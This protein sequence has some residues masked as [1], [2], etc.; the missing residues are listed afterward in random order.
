MSGS[1]ISSLRAYAFRMF[2]TDCAENSSGGISIATPAMR[3]NSSLSVTRSFANALTITDTDCDPNASGS[4][5]AFRQ[6][7]APSTENS[8]SS[9]MP[10]RANPLSVTATAC[11]SIPACLLSVTTEIALFAAASIQMSLPFISATAL[12]ASE[13]SLPCIV[14]IRL[15]TTVLSFLISAACR[16][17]S[18][19]S[20]PRFASRRTRFIAPTASS[21]EMSAE[22][23]RT[24]SNTST[25][26]ARLL[27]ED[28][29]RGIEGAPA[30]LVDHSG[31]SR[32]ATGD[33]VGLEFRC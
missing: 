13:R 22:D 19:E 29:L 14:S 25:S 20:M 18:P 30:E 31:C 32:V 9:R 5:L 24:G 3:S 8:S 33:D 27:N 6:A 4:S 21:A 17:Y 10:A 15:S 23:A 12:T 26:C 28:R 7:S 16:P 1:C 2:A 11:M